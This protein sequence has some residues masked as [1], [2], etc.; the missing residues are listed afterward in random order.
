MTTYIS[1]AETLEDFKIVEALERAVWSYSDLNIVGKDMLIALSHV[2]ACIAIAWEREIPVGVLLGFPTK[3]ADTQHSHMLGVLPE[4]RK[5]SIARDLKMF[6]RDWCLERGITRVVWTFDPLRAL[7]A[8]FNIA[9]LGATCTTYLPHF[10][11]DMDGI[12]AGVASDRVVAD[13]NLASPKGS[14]VA[15][16]PLVKIHPL[17]YIENPKKPFPSRLYFALPQDFGELL[18][19]DRAQAVLWRERSS[20]LLQTLLKTHQITGFCREGGNAYLLEQK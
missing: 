19:H 7:N 5:S 13:W 2:G 16:E 18:I 6:Q 4:Y 12:N 17:E 10:Y 9:K 14:A 3:Q 1:I 11:G 20:P 15:L 8:N